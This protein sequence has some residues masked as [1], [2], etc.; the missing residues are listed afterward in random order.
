MQT[1]SDL[2]TSALAAANRLPVFPVSLRRALGLLARGDDVSVQQLAVVIESDVVLAGKIVAIANSAF[3]ARGNQV[4]SLNRAIARIG[5]QKTQNALLGVSVSRMFGS[6]HLPG[7]WPSARF[8]AHSLA[9]ATLSDLIVRF[10]PAM[11]PEWAFLAGLFH[12]I[13]LLLIAAGLPEEYALLARNESHGDVEY[14]RQLLGFSHFELGAD[15]LARWNFAPCVRTAVRNC[16]HAGLPF[17]KPLTLAAVA[18]MASRL[19]DA[20]GISILPSNL[21]S[22]LSAPL[23]PAVE[24]DPA[25]ELLAALSIPDPDRFL[26]TFDLE[27]SELQSSAA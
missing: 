6:V 26:M 15:L 12:D 4:T 14:E 16:E 19:A 20:K 5:I 22:S 11:D 21:D 8:N 17:T 13:G 3:Y 7:T 24:G 2:R 27:Y 18:T 1:I 9:T 25:G 10:L 23:D